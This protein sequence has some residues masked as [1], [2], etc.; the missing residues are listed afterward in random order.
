MFYTAVTISAALCIENAAAGITILFFLVFFVF[1]CTAIEKL[2]MR[3]YCCHALVGIRY[4]LLIRMRPLPAEK[5]I[6]GN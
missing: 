5:W 6:F 1:S 2:H 4:V 3:H